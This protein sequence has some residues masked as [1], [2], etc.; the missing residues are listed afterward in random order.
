MISKL[1]FILFAIA[2]LVEFNAFAQE[3]TTRNPWQMKQEQFELFENVSVSEL[4][5]SP[6]SHPD[7]GALTLPG[8]SKSSNKPDNG[9]SPQQG[10]FRFRA[11]PSHYLKDDPIVFPDQPG[12]SHLHMFFGNTRADAYSEVGTG[13]QDDLL[14]RGASSVQG[15]KG[16]NASA[17]WIPALLDGPL[18]GCDDQR[19]IILPDN[20]IVY[21]K[22]RRP[23]ETQGGIPHGLEVIGGNLTHTPGQGMVHGMTITN[24]GGGNYRQGAVWG[25]YDPSRGLLVDP[26]PTI[27][28]SNP[29]GYKWLRAVIAFPQ[30]FAIEADGQVK[31]SSP[32]N[33][34]HQLMLEDSQGY[35]QDNLICPDSHPYRIPRIEL[36]I[37]FRWPEN[38]DTST[39]RLSSDMG[40]DTAAKV[41]HPGGSLH[42][43]ILF[44]WNLMVGKSW[45]ENCH[46]PSNPRNCSNGHTG[47]QWRLEGIDNR[48]MITNSVYTGNP[49]LSDP[50]DCEVSCPAAGTPCN[51]E[52]PNTTNDVENGNCNCKGTTIN[53]SEQEI[54]NLNMGITI[55]GSDSDWSQ[56]SYSL[57][58]KIL[59]NVTSDDD[60]SAKFKAQ[61][62][63]EYLYI[64]VDVSDDILKN[65]SEKPHQDDSVEIYIDGDNSKNSSYDQNDHQLVFEYNNQTV[66]HYPK[67]QQNPTGIT[68]AQTTTDSGY[69]IETKIA[70]SFIGIDPSINNKL[71]LDIHINDDDNGGDRD[72]KTSWN[73]KNDIAW[74]DTSVFGSLK[75][76]DCN[77][78]KVVSK[79]SFNI[80]PNP[81]KENLHIVL[82]NELKEKY[83][84][85][86]HNINGALIETKWIKEKNFIID[87]HELPSNLYFISI[88]GKKH[89]FKAKFFKE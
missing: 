65:D 63:S 70:W 84:L 46:N 39:W 21:Y 25:F 77:S 38:N 13:S 22:T 10:Q 5:N 67:N 48:P 34:D 69:M 12:A 40:A 41:P 57:S 44:A 24:S 66:Y 28:K 45:K 3:S 82:P 33:L 2:L 52:D 19:K 17:Y 15:G 60:L 53:Q 80:F 29:K 56:N 58:N 83:L 9:A 26:Q 6:G 86:I 74:K 14:V 88:T 59:G 64:L 62:D 89:S 18:S 42:G 37:D 75:L 87:I 51:D 78:S 31:L 4:N 36:L 55:D 11:A 20:I 1:N 68:F 35:S 7:Y 81:T 49:Y 23:A 61:W 72:R 54:C 8:V 50:Y 32:N 76:D 43:D 27:P 30:C 71:G 16:A 47:T 73:A 85:K 79:T